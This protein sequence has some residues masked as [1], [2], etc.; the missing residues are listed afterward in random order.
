M[1]LRSRGFQSFLP[2]TSASDGG[3]K[4]RRSSVDRSPQTLLA[5]LLCATIFSKESLGID[6]AGSRLNLLQFLVA[7]YGHNHIHRARIAPK[8]LA[9]LVAILLVSYWLHTIHGTETS[10]FFKQGIPMILIFT[11]VCS[12][13]E[14]IGDQNILI[15]AYRHVCFVASLF[16]LIQY[17]LSLVGYSL[18]MKV[19]GR[20]DSFSQEPSY[21]AIAIA[22]AFYF[23]IRDFVQ[24]NGKVYIGAFVL[25]LAFL[26]TLSVTA[27]V[28]TGMIATI[29]VFQKRGAILGLGILASLF[30]IYVNQDLL[31]QGVQSKVA[32]LEAASDYEVADGEITNLSVL[33][34]AANWEVALNTIQNGRLLGNGFGGHR[35]AHDD[36]YVGSAYLELARYGTNSIGGHS[37]FIRTVSEFGLLGLCIY[38]GVFLKGLLLAK[39][40]SRIWWLILSI[41]LAGRAI[42]HAGTFDVGLP[43]FI[44]APIVFSTVRDRRLLKRPRSVRTPRKNYQEHKSVS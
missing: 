44:L 33:S 38:I 31:P 29:L 28:L 25:G 5:L 11:G 17:A 43:I 41:I 27:T 2:Q 21:F 37:L 16:G 15:A 20:L 34:P 1:N 10:I 18:L 36:Y 26:L 8:V 32:A 3:A 24:S 4:K 35:E 14:R 40:S 6:I 30:Y 39:N 19:D 12:V 22:P 7:F 9:S 13:I 23:A 42:K